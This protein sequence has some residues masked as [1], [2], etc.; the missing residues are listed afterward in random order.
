M[1]ALLDVRGMSVGIPA[2]RSPTL[3][4]ENVSFHVQAGEAFGIVGE[5]GCGKSTT[6]RAVIRLLS[7]RLRIL[8]GSCS[9]QG[10]DLFQ[11]S[12]AALEKIR[13]AGI[14]MVF[15]DPTMA[16]N[17]VLTVGRQI[18]EGLRYHTPAAGFR[19]GQ[20]VEEVLR[21]VGA[22]DPAR[23]AAAFPHEL[24]GGLRQRAAIAM[25]LACAPRLLLAD[26]PT[27][28]LD[29]T[30]Q[31]QIL[32]LLSEL[33]VKLSMALVLV[34]HDL[35]VIA[36]TCDRVAVM[37]AGRIVEEASVQRLF[38]APAH[39]YT[40]ALLNSIPRGARA[41]HALR[42]IEGMPPDP[43]HRPRGCSFAPRCPRRQARCETVSPD[44]VPWAGGGMLACHNPA[45]VAGTQS[46]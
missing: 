1:T 39:P 12:E 40:V 6:I 25:A 45:L 20:R 34:T 8:A 30:I 33:R 43:A 21:L 4:V 22:P 16:L 15:Q 38:S 3:L 46:V 23:I 24:S 31:D 41:L 9:F 42:P 35:G 7:G 13:G 14:G 32:R 10:M 27:T 5:S 2:S 18:A 37:Y 11:L 44:L 28:A 26:E 29:V 17:P 19:G 36:Q